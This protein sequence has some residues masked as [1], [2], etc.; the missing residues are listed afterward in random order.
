MHQAFM[1][2][3]RRRIRVLSHRIELKFSDNRPEEPRAFTYGSFHDLI[4]VSDIEKLINTQFQGYGTK[5]NFKEKSRSRGENLRGTH[6]VRIFDVSSFK[7]ERIG[8]FPLFSLK[9][10][11][12]SGSENCQLI[13]RN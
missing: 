12:I 11:Q 8:N 3:F 6:N 1:S 2:I 10:K 13:I 4:R 9:K 7:T 5:L